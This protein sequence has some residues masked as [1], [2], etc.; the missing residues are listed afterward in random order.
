MKLPYFLLLAVSLVMGQDTLILKNGTQY[1]GHVIEIGAN[2][3]DFEIKS[4]SAY[5]EWVTQRIRLGLVDQIVLEDVTVAWTATDIGSESATALQ[6]SIQFATTPQ[7]HQTESTNAS[8][9][10]DDLSGEQ[11][12]EYNRGKLSIEVIGQSSGNIGGFGSSMFGAATQSTSWYQWTAYQGMGKQLTESEF[13]KLTGYDDEAQKAAQRMEKMK[14]ILILGGLASVGGMIVALIPKTTTKVEYY[15]YL[16]YNEYEEIT[17]TYP[18]LWPGAIVSVV[19]S[20]FFYSAMMQARKNYAPS[21]TVQQIAD[22][23]NQQ[24]INRIAQ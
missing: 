22:D 7:E 12:K 3:V 11:K 16:G 14:N 18:Y 21:S 2:S 8:F 1:Q 13:L 15:E 6:D 10:I 5:V 19:G 4:K 17:Y 9:T 24:L 23:Y 20:G